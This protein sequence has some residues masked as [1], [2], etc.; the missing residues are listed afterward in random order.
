MFQK[1]EPHLV[2]YEAPQGMSQIDLF[3]V[4]KTDRKE[5]VDC[6]VIPSEWEEGQHKLVVLDVNWRAEKA[7][8][9]R[10]S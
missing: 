8:S 3:L 1:R 5:C 6:K 4:R 7:K 9:P 2:T 10:V